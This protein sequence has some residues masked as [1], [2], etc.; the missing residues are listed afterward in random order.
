MVITMKKFE[1][2]LLIFSLVLG[3]FP[4]AAFATEGSSFD[5]D[6]ASYLNNTST[7]RGFDVTQEAI[8]KSLAGYEKTISDFTTVDDISTLLGEV[9]KADNS[10]LTAIYTKYNLDQASLTQ[11][12]SEYGEGLADYVFIHDLDTAL[13]L[14]IQSTTET[15]NTTT[16]T[17][18]ET[19]TDTTDTTTGNKTPQT[20]YE[21]ELVTYLATISEIRGFEVSRD[22]INAYLAK[23]DINIADFETVEELG[24]SLGDV[25][26]ADLSNLDYFSA[27]YNMDQQE[28]LQLKL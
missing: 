2:L 10:N 3:M 4:Q 22:A 20:G 12:L 28:I 9:I 1:L 16:D 21:A 17:S 5:Q 19:T 26:K 8:D 13:A 27:E 7:E 11:L 25:I 23:Y 15:T 18:S 6:L 14:Y 24:Y